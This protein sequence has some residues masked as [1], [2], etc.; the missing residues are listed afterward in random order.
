MKYLKGFFVLK[1]SHSEFLKH[2]NYGS[3]G[4]LL[5]IRL[6]FFKAMKKKRAY[7]KIQSLNNGEGMIDNTIKLGRNKL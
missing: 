3:I 7:N 6:H 5:G 1:F 4:W 2:K